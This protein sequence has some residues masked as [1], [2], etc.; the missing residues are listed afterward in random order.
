MEGATKRPDPSDPNW[1]DWRFLTGK[2][3]S[4]NTY[5]SDPTLDRT[6]R[7]WP[8]EEPAWVQEIRNHQAAVLR[9]ELYRHLDSM[10][11]GQRIRL[12][13]SVRGWT[14]QQAA[15]KLG[16]NRRTVIRHEQGE[17]QAQFS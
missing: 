6:E 9:V 11:A 17:H 4:T 15:E 2:Y 16:I 10:T 3:A 12:L 14:Q 8:Q 7:P 1:Q 13:R 5:V